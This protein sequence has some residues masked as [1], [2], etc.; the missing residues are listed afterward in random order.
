MTRF[1]LVSEKRDLAQIT[2][3]H[4]VCMDLMCNA[5]AHVLTADLDDWKTKAKHLDAFTI[6]DR[7]HILCLD[8]EKLIP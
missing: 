5:P 3:S 8:L 4:Q 1:Y 2:L 6:N 7:Y